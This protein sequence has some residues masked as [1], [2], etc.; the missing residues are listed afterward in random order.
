M[1]KQTTLAQKITIEGRG[2]F[3]SQP[4][5]L[6]LRPAPEDTGVVFV[7]TDIADRPRI[8]VAIDAVLDM[9]QRTALHEGP[10]TVETVEHCLAAISAMGVDNV[11][12]ELTAA[13]LPNIDGSCKPYADAVAAAGIVE[14][15]AAR[16]VLTITDPV[17][18]SQDGAS[19]Y[20]M[21]GD[22]DGLSILYELEYP[23]PCIGR[24]WYHY[25]STEDDFLTQIAPARTFTTEAM[26]RK[27]R[28]M[29]LFPAP[30]CQ[31]C[32]GL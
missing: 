1:P 7:R 15:D 21:P 13:E 32:A 27:A 10:H 26:A 24:Q 14:Q 18:V 17:A 31:G 23:Q 2:L 22:D 16:E 11:L 4:C 19:L 5:Q 30:Q 9:P 3:S 20:A 8:A 12:I 28:E 6:T 29:G 25:R